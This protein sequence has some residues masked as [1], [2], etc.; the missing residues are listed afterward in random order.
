MEVKR[1]ARIDRRVLAGLKAFCA[2]NPGAERLLLSF[3]PEP[4]LLDGIRCEA[5]KPWLRFLP[6]L[7]PLHS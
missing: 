4:L 2:D 6:P 1:S 7:A 3:A 5:V